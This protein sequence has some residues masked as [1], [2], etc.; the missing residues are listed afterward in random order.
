M[1]E[2]VMPGVVNIYRGR[3]QADVNTLI[4]LD[5]SDPISEFPGFKSLLCEVQK[6]TEEVNF[7]E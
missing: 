6:A 7:H 5:Y 4:D 2:K 1:T 3:P